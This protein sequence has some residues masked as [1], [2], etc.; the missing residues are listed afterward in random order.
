MNQAVQTLAKLPALTPRLIFGAG[1]AL[2][3]LALS[4]AVPVSL[5]VFVVLTF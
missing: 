2:L 3:N 4:A 5:V 1:E